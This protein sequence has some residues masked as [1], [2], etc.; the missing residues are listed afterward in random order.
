MLTLNEFNKVSDGYY[1][2]VIVGDEI[3]FAEVEK[4]EGHK[5]VVSP[6]EYDKIRGAGDIFLFP[7]YWRLDGYG[8]DSL[9]K[10]VGEKAGL[11]AEAEEF[12]EK[13]IT[14]KKKGMWE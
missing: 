2:F 3:R 10:I 9:R 5:S 1:K 14:R 7:D 13:A 8:S 4:G 6:E 12:V 11:S